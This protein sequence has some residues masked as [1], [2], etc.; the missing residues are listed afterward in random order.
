[1]AR[2]V[3]ADDHALLRSGLMRLLERDHAI[4]AEA[5]N[6][7]T[8]LQAVDAERPDVLLLDLY[9]PGCS[10]DALIARL[11][12][13]HP[14]LR[15][16]VMSGTTDHA[17]LSGMIEVGAS[18]IVLKSSG[19]VRLR[20]AI[21]RVLGHE[22]YVDPDLRA[23]APPLRPSLTPRESEVMELIAHGNSYREIG[24]RLRLGERTIETYRRR[25]ADKLGVRS[26][27]E[28]VAYAV[29]H[30]LVQRPADASGSGG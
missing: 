8:T 24:A 1:M 14:E 2:L 10:A 29:E 21:A 4:V 9:M 7:E 3:I 18:A 6:G 17:R 13:D 22:I 30:G 25:I 26:R 19:V 20:E 28:L 27:A 15:I 16:V 23:S 12:R 5:F 11:R